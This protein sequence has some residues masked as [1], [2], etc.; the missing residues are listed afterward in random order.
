VCRICRREGEKLF[1]KGDR[2]VAISATGNRPKCAVERR[3]YAPGQHGQ[4]RKKVSQYGIQLRQ[5][6]RLRKIYGINERQFHN[7]FVK[8][9]KQKGVLGENFLRILERRLDNIV[10]RL[11]F[12]SSRTQARQLVSH[13]HIRVNGRKVNIPSYLVRVGDQVELK[14]KQR[15]EDKNQ[16][17]YKNF[18]AVVTATLE[19]KARS[20][21]Q[22]LEIEPANFRGKVVAFPAR[23]EIQVPVNEQ[24][25]VEYYSR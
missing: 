22:W 23:E 3:G 17:K 18:L 5:K 2:C 10:Y 13:G 21:P 6:Q 1:L 14:M 4:G 8:A 25:V 24:L 20:A 16:E 19:G 12:A 15:A 9:E 11:G 7:Y